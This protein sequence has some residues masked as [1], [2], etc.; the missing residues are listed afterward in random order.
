MKLSIFAGVLPV[1]TQASG[2]L[3]ERACTPYT[4][5]LTGQKLCCDESLN[6]LFI[7]NKLLGLGICCALGSVLEGLSCKTPPLPPSKP[8]A[9]SGG[10]VCAGKSGVDIGLQYGHCY[11]LQSVNGL[12]LGHDYATKYE[13]D[14]ENP[15]VVFRVCADTDKGCATR[16]D[17]LVGVN[18]TW[19]MQDQ[20]GDPAGTGFGW[21]GGSGDLSVQGTPATALEVAGSQLC[22]G[23]KCAICIRFPPGGAHAPCP[24]SPGQS[25][26]G[27][28]ANPNSCQPFIWQEVNCRSE[29]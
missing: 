13:I 11:V 27:V 29:L 6:T 26:L 23:G 5:A 15:G 9:C 21:L 24:L 10:P 12:Y 7:V 14:G 4:S 18:G 17:S 25:H 19:W 8:A 3:A 1:A 22:F 2:L 16:A 20:M 28:A